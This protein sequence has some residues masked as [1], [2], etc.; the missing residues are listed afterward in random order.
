[1]TWRDNYAEA[2]DLDAIL[3]AVNIFGQTDLYRIPFNGYCY[4]ARSGYTSLGGCPN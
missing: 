1:M 3:C 4:R 2:L